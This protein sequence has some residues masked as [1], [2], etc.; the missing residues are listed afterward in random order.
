MDVNNAGNSDIIHQL[1]IFENLDISFQTLTQNSPISIYITDKNGDCE[2]VN[3]SWCEMSGLTQEEALGK[4]WINGIHSE[5]RDSIKEKWYNSIQSGGKWSFEYR[6]QNKEGLVTWVL[7]YASEVFDKHNNLIHYIGSNIDITYRKKVEDALKLSEEKFSKAFMM[8]PDSLVV[9][10]LKD[11]CYLDVNKGFTDIT[12]Y[13]REDV[14]GYSSLSDNLNLWVDMEEREKLIKQLIKDNEVNSFEFTYRKKD[15]SIR[16][17]SLSAKIIEISD[18]PCIISINRDITENRQMEEMLRKSEE[19]FHSLFERAPLGYQSLD[20]NG[21][22]IEVNQTWLDI[23]GYNQEDVKGKWFGDFLVPEFVD[24]FRVRFPQFKNEGRIHSEFQMLAKD[25]TRRFIAF[26][27]R[28]GYKEDGTFKQTHCILSDVTELKIAEEAKQKMIERDRHIAE[29]FQQ[30]VAPFGKSIQINGYDFANKY[31]A[32]MQE[33]EVG[34]DFCDVFDLGDG[35]IG[36]AIGDIVGKGL[37]AAVHVTAA[38]QM[39]KSYAL[40][41][42]RPSVVMSLVND[43]LCKEITTENDMLTAF[44]AILD[45]NTHRL[46][47]S[48]AGHEPPLIRSSNGDVKTLRLGGPMFF[49][50]C[51]QHYKQDSLKLNIGDVFVMVTD[52]ITEARVDN[53][54]ELFG[55]EGII[56]CLGRNAVASV[57]EIAVALI[58]DAT[59]FANGIIR[60][61]IAIIII[62]RQ[63]MK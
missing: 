39:I 30:S 56:N 47:Y 6:F 37:L 52:G 63:T 44:Y 34:G 22:F 14:I 42:S 53:K 11:G 32:S 54:S 36:I 61:D 23:L 43:A 2:Y 58:E 16:I 27:G 41:D 57:E 40:L 45:T 18:E 46:T 13:T 1:N 50:M 49:G 20:E 60:D 29:V 9:N 35:K 31:K 51:K 15:G 62:K 38:R 4:G 59:L 33:S 55:T 21:C 5:D 28:I 8:S 7:G 10:R 26:D 17:G 48:N 3:R 19:R 12:G 25:G 24:A